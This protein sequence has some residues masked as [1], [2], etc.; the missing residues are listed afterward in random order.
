MANVG[1]AFVVTAVP[2]YLLSAA[3]QATLTDLAATGATLLPLFRLW[4]VFYNSGLYLLE[5][6]Y[7]VFLGLAL[8]EVDGP[9]WLAWLGVLGGA[10]QVFN[11]SA[12]WIHAP[13][14]AT[15]PGNIAVL[16]WLT[17][18]S[19]W[20]LRRAPAPTVASA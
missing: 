14:A 19:V 16:T 20:L 3:L 6:G 1:F 10:L 17:G 9:R 13:D 4:D 7:L 11:A 5:A 12:L 2:C 18:A 8:R 15:I